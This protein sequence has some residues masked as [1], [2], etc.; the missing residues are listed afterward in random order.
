MQILVPTLVFAS[1]GVLTFVLL[2]M[3]FSEERKVAR[4]L[5]NV[6]EW[7]AQQAG[8]AEPLLR[9]FRARVV[10]PVTTALGASLAGLLP[11]NSRD[12][13]QRALDL[14]GNPGGLAPEGVLAT[15]I[16]C[17]IVFPALAA[18]GVVLL[19][20]GFNLWSLVFVA[21]CAVGGYLAPTFWID[22]LKRR[23]QDRIRLALPD[24]LDMLTIS[25]QAGLGFDMALTKLVR[26]TSGPLAEE[27]ARMLA[28]VQAGVSRRDGLRHLGERTDVPEL[29]N[30]IMAMIQAEVFGVSVSGILL[31]QAVE[32]RKKRQ[33]RAEELG[34]KAPVKMVFPTILCM[35]PATM[36]V[37]LGPAVISI[38]RAFGIVR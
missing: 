24:M 17:A 34:Q 11:S 27:F 3:V 4:A 35:L 20:G 14:A 13:M 1:V 36:L 19:S 10:S 25:V 16:V 23:R 6:S 7:E 18:L 9:P 21:A 12:R 15:S 22:E 31:S 37:I 26:N 29:R 8:E 2:G 33:Q 38:G 28:E 30:F 5:R 32:L